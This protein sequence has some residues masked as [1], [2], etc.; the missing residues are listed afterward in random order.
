MTKAEEKQKYNTQN[1]NDNKTNNGNN[2]ILK[3][4]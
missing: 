2:G 3:I 4:R 1:E